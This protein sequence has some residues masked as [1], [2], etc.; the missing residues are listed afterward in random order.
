MSTKDNESLLTVKGT[1]DD[2]EERLGL[3]EQAIF[4]TKKG[5]GAS[6]GKTLFD[7]MKEK[8]LQMEAS[9]KVQL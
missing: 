3:L 4:N 7:D 9:T 5:A 6:G 2:H 8:L 1:Q